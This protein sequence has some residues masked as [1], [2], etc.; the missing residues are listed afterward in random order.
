MRFLFRLIPTLIGLLSAGVFI[1]T[2]FAP[3]L[4]WWWMA[5]LAV[6]LAYALFELLGRRLRDRD[7][8]S[9]TLLL[10]LFT[11]GGLGFLLYL[12]SLLM[13]I[14]VSVLVA[15][16][17]GLFTEY[18]YRWFYTTDR[19]PSYALEVMIA[20]M[21]LFTVF[22]ITADVIGFRIFLRLPTWALAVSYGALMAVVYAAARFARSPFR[23]AVRPGALCGLLAAE[24]FWSIL[25]LPT[26]FMV[27]GALGALS[28]YIMTGLVRVQETGLP[29]GAPVRR[30]AFLGGA[31]FLLI[32]GT[33]RWI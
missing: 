17:A 16:L 18:L 21:E 22:F 33:A 23:V 20:L 32:L 31:L 9:A 3:E 29:L 30:Y 1:A 4:F 6:G 7:F 19:L 11:A 24:L 27:G 10:E 15:V 2:Y 25:F 13:R 5:L 28:W 12:D 8:W 14:V 26:G